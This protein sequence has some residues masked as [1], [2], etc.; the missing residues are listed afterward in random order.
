MNFENFSKELF[1]LQ[2]NIANFLITCA[3]NFIIVKSN[4][5]MGKTTIIN[6]I[7]KE[8]KEVIYH[9]G[10]NPHYYTK[11]DKTFI[12]F[13]NKQK[14]KNYTILLDEYASKKFIK[15]LVDLKFKKTILFTNCDINIKNATILNLEQ[16]YYN[17][18]NQY[19]YNNKE[20]CNKNIVEIKLL[21]E[22]SDKNEYEEKI[23]KLNQNR[24]SSTSTS[25]F[26]K[27]NSKIKE[28]KQNFTEYS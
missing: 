16:I 5:F 21:N 17:F 11:E 18:V 20:Y 28:Y 13:L 1:F 19:F 2:Q 6:I 27:H 25:F 10:C 4:R 14:Q 23:K 15:T 8:V 7:F 3:D 24:S 26:H 22:I 9:T 12:D